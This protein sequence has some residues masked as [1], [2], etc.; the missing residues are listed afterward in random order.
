MTGS[1]AQEAAGFNT[2]SNK[3]N[4]FTVPD[5]GTVKYSYEHQFPDFTQL[6]LVHSSSAV[7]ETSILQHVQKDKHR[8][9]SCGS[10]ITARKYSGILEIFRAEVNMVL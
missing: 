3:H 2:D 7:R 5:R 4:M 1:D 8:M 10:K 9:V 6:A